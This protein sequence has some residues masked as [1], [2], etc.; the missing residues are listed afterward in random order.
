VRSSAAGKSTRGG[1]G[2]TLLE[3]LLALGLTTLLIGAVFSFLDTLGRRRDELE[4]MTIKA[5]EIGTLMDRIESDL[6]A[7]VVGDG[8]G[9]AGI[10]GRASE[11]SVLARRVVASP[12]SSSSSSSSS[13]SA[14]GSVFGELSRA[15]YAFD[16]SSGVVRAGR[17]AAVGDV[18]AT[19]VVAR[20]VRAL[21]FRFFDGRVWRSEFE[22]E[23]EARL[24]TA[25]E[26]A[27]WSGELKRDGS[28]GPMGAPDRVRTMVIPDGPLAA[29]KE[30]R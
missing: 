7:S 14:G 26:I 11:L 24:P 19:E 10:N 25:V 4:R 20:G 6:A 16:V 27:V 21:R 28:G 9:G 29:W 1:G 22:S 12:G 3:V 15:K 5:R 13:D 8:R 18:S 30:E 17:G 23:K 2:F